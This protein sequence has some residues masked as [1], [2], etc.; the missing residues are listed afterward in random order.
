MSIAYIIDSTTDF[1][2]N[3][4]VYK[5]PFHV[6][7]EKGLMKKEYKKSAI[8]ALLDYKENEKP[9]IEPTPGAYRELYQSLQKQGY[10]HIVVIPGDKTKSISYV[11]ADYATMITNIDVKVIDVHELNTTPEDVLNYILN[12]EEQVTTFDFAALLEFLKQAFSSLT[13]STR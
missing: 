9:F 7:V 4:H 5:V 2:N 1:K 10:E 6:Y 12:N 3:E 8:T 13:L 11:N